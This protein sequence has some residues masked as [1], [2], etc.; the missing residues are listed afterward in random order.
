M[1]R[2]RDYGTCGPSASFTV[3]NDSVT[4]RVIG[5]QSGNNQTRESLQ[6]H[7]TVDII[8]RCFYATVLDRFRLSGAPYDGASLYRRASLDFVSASTPYL[9]YHLVH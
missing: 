1:P 9:Q 5:K 4:A 7:L 6:I 2:R 3:Y 8:A